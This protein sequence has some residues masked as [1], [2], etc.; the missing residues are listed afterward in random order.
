MKWK[1]RKS[2]LLVPKQLWLVRTLLQK[3][4]PT[5]SDILYWHY[6]ADDTATFTRFLEQATAFQTKKAAEAVAFS[7][8]VKYPHKVG[9]FEVISKMP[10]EVFV[11]D[12]PESHER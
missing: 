12:G 6:W 10:G 5:N 3:G 9:E 2:G 11:E 8:S 1:K 4:D 7:L